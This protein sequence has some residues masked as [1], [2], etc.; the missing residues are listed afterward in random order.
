MVFPDILAVQEVESLQTLKQFNETYLDK[1]FKYMYLVD[2]NDSRQI[3][4]GFLSMFPAIK[5]RTHQFIP[6]SV[7]HEHL[8]SRD[9]L[10]ID[11]AI[12][13]SQEEEGLE[14]TDLDK[15]V[16]IL[17][18][19]NNHLKSHF[20][21]WRKTGEEKDKQIEADNQKRKRQSG[22]VAKLVKARFA[23]HDI[24]NRFFV[25]CGDFNDDPTTPTLQ[26]LL[27]MGLYNVI[28]RLSGGTAPYEKTWT[29]YYEKEDTLHQYDYLLFSKA[30][31]E[32][33]PDVLPTIERRGVAKYKK[34]QTNHGFDL[35]RF[36][37]VAGKATEAS[38]HCPVY[39]EIEI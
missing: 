34:L 19:F 30:L 5:I 33:N 25:V 37:G 36:T 32:K 35:E 13:N 18:F 17:T 26:D 29:Y 31:A 20:L 4:V 1:H 6:D 9:C 15:Q 28:S 14:K 39:I 23:N 2:G 3:D 27:A 21:D 10:E 12:T 22:E 24:D 8:F 11:F 16:P 38:D 7:T